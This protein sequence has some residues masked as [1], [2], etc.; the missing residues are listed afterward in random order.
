MTNEQLEQRIN[1]LQ[2][3]IDDLKNINFLHPKM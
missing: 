3:Q 2:F 1:D